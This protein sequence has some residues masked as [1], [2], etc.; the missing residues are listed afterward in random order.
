M[1]R[2]FALLMILSF[3]TTTGLVMAQGTAASSTPASSMPAKKKTSHKIKHSKKKIS[4][5]KM[6]PMSTPG[7]SD[8]K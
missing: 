7:A 5:K 3:L 2:L 8:K 6:A 4:K 1:K